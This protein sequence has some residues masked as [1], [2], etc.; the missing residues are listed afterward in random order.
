[1][2]DDGAVGSVTVVVDVD[3]WVADVDVVVVDITDGLADD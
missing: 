1:M 3:G 2:L